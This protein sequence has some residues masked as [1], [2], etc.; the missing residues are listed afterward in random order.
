MN[1]KEPIALALPHRAGDTRPGLRAAA[2]S[3]LAMQQGEEV[4][5][6]RCEDAVPAFEDDG[7]QLGIPEPVEGRLLP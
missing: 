7:H 5:N 2:I 4:G 6:L 3:E 1:R